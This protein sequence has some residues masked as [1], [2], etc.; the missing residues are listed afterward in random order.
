M[1]KAAYLVSDPLYTHVTPLTSNK[2]KD[3][4]ISCRRRPENL[5]QEQ[6][7]VCVNLPVG[8]RVTGML[9]MS[10]SHTGQDRHMASSRQ[11][12][13]LFYSVERLGLLLLIKQVSDISPCL[14]VISGVCTTGGPTATTNEGMSSSKPRQAVW[15]HGKSGLP[16]VACHN[17]CAVLSL[18]TPCPVMTP[19]RWPSHLWKDFRWQK[20]NLISSRS[21]LVLLGIPSLGAQVWEARS[22]KPGLDNQI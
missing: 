16:R 3:I 17:D 1:K 4:Q 18:L 2:A 11:I 5:W 12:D 22:R 14:T 21:I 6:Q 13:H 19:R 10:V 20:I 15:W 7:S 8:P 9:L